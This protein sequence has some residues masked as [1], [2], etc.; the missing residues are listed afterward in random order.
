MASEKSA[1]V[2]PSSSCWS[3]I[4]SNPSIRKSKLISFCLTSALLLIMSFLWMSNPKW[5]SLQM[6]L[7]FILPSQH[8]LKKDLDNLECCSHNGTCNLTPLNAFFLSHSH[9][10]RSK[11]PIPTRYT[12]HNCILESVSSAKYFVVD[13]SSDLSWDM[14]INFISKKTNNTLGFLRRN[15][16]LV[17]PQLEYCFTV[18]CPFTDSIISKLEAVQR[19]ATWWVKHDYGQTSSVTDIMQSLHWCRLDQR[20]IDNKLSL[21]YKI[22]NNL[23]AISI[24]DFLIPLNVRPSRHYHLLSYRLITATTDYNKFSFFP[25]AV[26]HFHWSNLLLKTVACSTLD[27]FNQAVCKIDHVSP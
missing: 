12:F 15:T 27:Q 9:L 23:I 17:H 19:R 2:N 20:R 4:F 21:L 13:I 6:T 25:R 24:S 8:L 1:L 14:H 16:V 18:W 11:K 26:F 7:L 10:T 22:T 3:M 5:D